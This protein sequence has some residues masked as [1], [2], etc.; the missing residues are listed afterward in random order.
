MTEVA[1]L[2]LAGCATALAT[3][4]GAIPVSHLGS[5]ADLL[6]PALWGLTVG[7]MTVASIVGLLLPALDEGSTS[8]SSAASRSEC[9]SCSRRGEPWRPATCTSAR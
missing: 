2:A 5:R 9:S 7:L 4:L 8:R 1:V 3:G 6:R